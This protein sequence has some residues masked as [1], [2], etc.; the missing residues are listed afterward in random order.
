VPGVR[1]CRVIW[2]LGLAAWGGSAAA[3]FEVGLGEVR[4]VLLL[5]LLLVVRFRAGRE[6]LVVDGGS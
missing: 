6:R 4:Q 2:R 3:A 5:L 1:F